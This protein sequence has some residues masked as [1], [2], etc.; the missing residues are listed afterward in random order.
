[1]RFRHVHRIPS[2]DFIDS[3][4][5]NIFQSIHQRDATTRIRFM[6]TIIIAIANHRAHIPTDRLIRRLVQSE[7]LNGENDLNKLELLRRRSPRAAV[8]RIDYLLSRRAMLVCNDAENC[9]QVDGLR[10]ALQVLSS[11]RDTS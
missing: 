4:N 1:M 5:A 7:M 6:I 2:R 8:F 10:D 9:P 11:I 3:I